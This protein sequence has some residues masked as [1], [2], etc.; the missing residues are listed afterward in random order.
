M[1]TTKVE[2]KCYDGFP[3][4]CWTAGRTINERANDVRTATDFPHPDEWRD[5]RRASFEYYQDI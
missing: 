1:A 4:D 3:C 2:N 5:G